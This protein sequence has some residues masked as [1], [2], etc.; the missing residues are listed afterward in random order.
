M[1]YARQWEE[2]TSLLN[3]TMN[4]GVHPDVVTFNSL[5]N[6]LCKEK[7]TSEAFTVL[8][9]MIQRNVKPNVVTYNCSIYEFCS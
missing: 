3:R 7:R 4:E 8:E 6:A 1:P 2:T 9:L 5:I